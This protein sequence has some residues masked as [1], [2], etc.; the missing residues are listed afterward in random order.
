MYRSLQ[1]ESVS[2][3]LET[4]KGKKGNVTCNVK[5]TAGSW[6]SNIRAD[7]N[8]LPSFLLSDKAAYDES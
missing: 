2:R 7:T 8:I 6:R 1:E 3:N 5:V 4:G